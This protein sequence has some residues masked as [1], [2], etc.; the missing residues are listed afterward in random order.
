MEALR[1]H[2]IKKKRQQCMLMWANF[3]V[4]AMI[5]GSM[6]V[7]LWQPLVNIYLFLIV[8]TTTWIIDI[9]CLRRIHS[10]MKQIGTILP[11]KSSVIV[12]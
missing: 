6:L 11:N 1:E 4:Y 7:S 2:K 9:I 5:S 10:H 12:T 3:L 8:L